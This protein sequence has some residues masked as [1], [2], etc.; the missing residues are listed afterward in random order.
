MSDHTEHTGAASVDELWI[1]DWAAEGI[2]ALERHLAKHAAFAA[3][4]AARAVLDSDHGDGAPAA[5]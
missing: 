1:H 5:S 4:L 3:F 2:A